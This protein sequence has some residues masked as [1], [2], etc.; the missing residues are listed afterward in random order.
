MRAISRG[1]L[2]LKEDAVDFINW[3]YQLDAD[4][5]EID[6]VELVDWSY[7]RKLTVGAQFKFV[8]SNI[9]ED[10]QL[11]PSAKLGASIVWSCPKTGL[12]D[13]TVPIT[14]GNKE[15]ISIF[16]NIDG[17]LLRNELKV[18]LQI[19]LLEDSNQAS[20]S[21][22]SPQLAGSIVWS[23][24]SRV[25]LEGNA[26]R[27]PIQKTSFRSLGTG[28][29]FAL[30]KILIE[31]SDLFAPADAC[32]TVLVNS[33]IQLIKNFFEDQ[34]LPE[35]QLLHSLLLID[36][37]RHM[38]RVAL[39][40]ID[41][42]HENVYPQGSLGLALRNPLLLLAKD[43]AALRNSYESDPSMIDAKLQSIF[44]GFTNV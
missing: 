13:G 41:F 25:I 16:A 36:L 27:M 3:S 21:K 14:L 34:D 37:Y 10:L 2:S 24:E 4:K 33:D 17:S 28:I 30:W 40:N 11:G 38:V 32:I 8:L 15:D 44:G 22:I 42:D 43:P 31:D 12:R 35:S 6:P 9:L 1:F 26:P 18:E 20:F 19:V 29:D 23:K 5:P 39:E 7:Y